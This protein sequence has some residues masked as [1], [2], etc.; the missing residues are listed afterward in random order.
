VR[1]RVLVV[2][3]NPVNAELILQ[4]LEDD[5]DVATARDGLEGLAAIARTRPH[6]VLMD[7]S[8]PNLDGEATLRRIRS[9]P[10]IAKTRVVALTAHAIKGRREQALTL[11]FDGFLTKPVDEDALIALVTR[12]LGD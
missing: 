10:A 5:Y 8:M 2:E 11:G 7:L 12:M 4:L 6:L 9:D 3:D 1:K